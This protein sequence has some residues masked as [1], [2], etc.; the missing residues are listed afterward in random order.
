MINHFYF[1]FYVDCIAMAKEFLQENQISIQSFKK[2]Q[3]QNSNLDLFSQ[4]QLNNFQ[5]KFQSNSKKQVN[6]YHFGAHKHEDG[7]KLTKKEKREKG[8]IASAD[9]GGKMF[10]LLV[11]QRRSLVEDRRRNTNRLINALKQYYPQPLEWFCHRDT[12]LF[13]DFLIK[14]RPYI[15]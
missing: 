10:A 1:P 2:I 4:F 6:D 3:N 15:R 11:E 5:L 7:T 14:W 13:C 9:T 12:E 8:A